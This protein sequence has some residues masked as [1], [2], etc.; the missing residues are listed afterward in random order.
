MLPH[1]TDV[2]AIPGGE[3]RVLLEKPACLRQGF[4]CNRQNRKTQV[5]DGVEEL[6]A[7]LW[8]P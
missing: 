6:E 5:G 3:A 7:N 2:H 4:F 8:D 1:D